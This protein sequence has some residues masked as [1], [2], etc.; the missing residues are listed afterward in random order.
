MSALLSNLVGSTW[1]F[2][3]EINFLVL[4]HNGLLFENTFIPYFIFV[5]EFFFFSLK[6]TFLALKE[7]L[8]ILCILLICLL[9]GFSLARCF[10]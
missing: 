7:F 3:L 4:I 8:V 10:F 6:L 5:L 1:C 9:F 2:N